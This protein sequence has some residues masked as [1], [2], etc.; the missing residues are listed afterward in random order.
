MHSK[1]VNLSAV[2]KTE[3]SVPLKT[4]RL[5]RRFGRYMKKADI[6]KLLGTP[7]RKRTLTLK[8]SL[9]SAMIVQGL[10]APVR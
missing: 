10:S 3:L 7:F 5:L 9:P 1:R 8:P 2:R 6:A 4:I